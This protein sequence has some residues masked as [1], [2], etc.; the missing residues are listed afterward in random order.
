MLLLAQVAVGVRADRFSM[1]RKKENRDKIVCPALS[2]SLYFSF[3]L[4]LSLSLS[5]SIAQ[6]TP[7]ISCPQSLTL[8]ADPFVNC[9]EQREK[10]FL[11]KFRGFTQR[12][13]RQ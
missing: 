12:K 13:I 6:S 10:G 4:S 7:P 9:V 2:L 3:S 1:W 5:L 11:W 8:A